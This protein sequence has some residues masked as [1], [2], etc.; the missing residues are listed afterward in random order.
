PEQGR[1][2][3]QAPRLRLPPLH[4]APADRAGDGDPAEAARRA[5]GALQGRQR[6]G[7]EAPRRRRREG[8]CGAGPGRA[9]GVGL[10]RPRAAQPPRDD[11]PVMTERQPPPDVRDT[12]MNDPLPAPAAGPDL[13]RRAFL[14][15]GVLSLGSIA[16][17]SLLA[18][19]GPGS[20]AAPPARPAPFRL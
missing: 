4:L 7:E 15:T 9:G 20:A 18:R 6:R 1:G 14:G 3:Q 11:S 8:R 17:S 19:C 10:R 12:T 16:L 5:A 13:A 2:R